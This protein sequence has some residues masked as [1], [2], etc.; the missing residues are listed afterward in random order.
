[1]C[2]SRDVSNMLR[3]PRPSV[4]HLNISL[5]PEHHH[6]LT[7]LATSCLQTLELRKPSALLGVPSQPVLFPPIK[8]HIFHK[9]VA[10]TTPR[11]HLHALLDRPPNTRPPSPV[12]IRPFC[13]RNTRLPPHAPV[14][15]PLQARP[16]HIP[17][18]R[19]RILPRQRLPRLDPA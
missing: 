5:S 14:A 18:P 17:H 11:W 6:Q 1:M 3:P 9:L 2:C 16:R 8:R 15:L 12:P 4:L 19:R 13:P 10:N 7:H